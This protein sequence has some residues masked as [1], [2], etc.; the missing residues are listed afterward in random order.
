LVWGVL[1]SLLGLRSRRLLARAARA[2]HLSART[3]HRLLK[4][5]W[6]IADLDGSPIL[7]APHMSEALHYRMGE[8]EGVSFS[9]SQ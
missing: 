3:Y 1:L 2:Y 6:T 9:H 4:V 5:A 8:R 7:R